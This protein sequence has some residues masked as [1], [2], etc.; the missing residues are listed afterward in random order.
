MAQYLPQKV[1]QVVFCRMSALQ[2][3]EGD[4]RDVMGWGPCMPC[5]VFV[6][7]SG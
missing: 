4:K 7:A 5:V 6:A 2:V 1:E 3:S